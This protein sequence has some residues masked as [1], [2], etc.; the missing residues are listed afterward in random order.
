MTKIS[1][2][3]NSQD[4][5]S[6]PAP[7][8]ADI[9]AYLETCQTVA[10]A[11]HTRP[12]GD[13]IGSLIGLGDALKQLG[14]DVTMLNLDG[15][16]ERYEFLECSSEVKR[17]ADVKSPLTVDAFVILDTADSKRVGKSVR[18]CVESC[19][20]MIALDHHVT[21]E[22][23]ADVNYIDDTSPATGQIVY[24]LIREMNWPLTAASRDAIWAAIVTDT[25]SY[26]YDSVTKRTFDIAGDLVAQGVAVGDMSA[27][28][29]QSY[30]PER[31]EL[32]REL[33]NSMEFSFGGKAASWKIRQEVT[34]RLG[35]TPVDQ[36]GLIDYLRAV[37][38]VIVAVSFEES[39]D[40]VR[41]SARSKSRDV[42]VSAIC[43]EFGGGGHVLAAGAAVAGNIDE[44][45][46]KFLE[47]VG[48]VIEG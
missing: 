20:L 9:G 36:E 15:A 26:Q 48:K 5:K 35:I 28:I 13:A 2:M 38:G 37:E 44:V 3:S 10:L 40:L 12:D 39:Q 7:T 22:R 32:L 17:S 46:K 18:A 25:G 30:R 6:N 33:L 23:F 31:L 47:R 45:A 43:Q 4:L 16:T 42:D 19:E 21:N 1:I 29:Y 24:E 11:S 8:L 41:I 14:K 34:E 27:R